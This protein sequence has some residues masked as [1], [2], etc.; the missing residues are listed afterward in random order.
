MVVLIKS[1][2]HAVIDKASASSE[3][4]VKEIKK[5]PEGSFFYKYL[6][7]III[8]GGDESAL[9][10]AARESFDAFG[11]LFRRDLRQCR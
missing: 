11:N 9:D 8:V 7:F 2:F 10:F 5:F 6:F 4:Q 3:L 1:I